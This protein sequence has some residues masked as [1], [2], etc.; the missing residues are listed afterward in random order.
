MNKQGSFSTVGKV[1]ELAAPII[2]NLGLILWDIRFEKEGPDWFLRIFIDNDSGISFDDCENVSRPLDKLLDDHDF[3]EMSYF[4]EVSSPGINRMLR[5]VEHFERY[6]G[7]EIIVKLVRPLDGN[8][9]FVGKL[10]SFESGAVNVDVE[11][12]GELN[13][14]LSDCSYIK[15]NDGIEIGELD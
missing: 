9:N 7:E 1:R 5:N 6:M 2:D 15:V 11:D 10:V 8:R 14:N 3:I 4:L 13:F 12:L